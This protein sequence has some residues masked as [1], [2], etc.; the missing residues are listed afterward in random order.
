MKYFF[1]ILASFLAQNTSF[2]TIA[3][4][5]LQT[6]IILD[7]HDGFHRSAMPLRQSICKIKFEKRDDHDL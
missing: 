2:Y 4:Y 1:R 6:D 7:R 5:F 3:T